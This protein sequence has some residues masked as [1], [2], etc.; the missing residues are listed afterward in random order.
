MSLALARGGG[1]GKKAHT[2][3]LNKIKLSFNTPSIANCTVKVG[4]FA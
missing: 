4:E 1:R 3:H 2:T